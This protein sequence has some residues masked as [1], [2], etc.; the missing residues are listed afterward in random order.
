MT[1]DELI[2]EILKMK[3]RADINKGIRFGW[4]LSKYLNDKEIEDAYASLFK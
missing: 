1:K 4:L 3:G 2:A